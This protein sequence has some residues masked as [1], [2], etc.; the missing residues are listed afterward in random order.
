MMMI[1]ILGFAMLACSLNSCFPPIENVSSSLEY[2]LKDPV[3][4][5]IFEARDKR[6]SDSL[7]LFLNN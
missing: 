2:S 3:V 4:K 6:N 1:R 5:Q 7:K